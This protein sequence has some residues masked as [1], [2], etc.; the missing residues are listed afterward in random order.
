MLVFAKIANFYSKVSNILF[1]ITI[2]RKTTLSC[3]IVSDG[4]VNYIIGQI[5]PPISFTFIKAPTPPLTLKDLD[6]F[7]QPIPAIKPTP[8]PPQ[9]PTRT[10][11]KGKVIWLAQFVLCI[12]FNYSV[13]FQFYL[14]YCSDS[15]CW[16]F[17]VKCD[18]QA[19][20]LSVS[21][22]R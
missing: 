4:G 21:I 17:S 12:I 7:Y 20:L 14:L 8:S 9:P 15:R 1:L 22:L 2:T 18:L 6:K 19:P 13:Y 5:S 3:L 10:I 11:L 16:L